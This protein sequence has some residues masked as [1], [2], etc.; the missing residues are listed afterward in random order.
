VLV[1]GSHFH[2]VFGTIHGASNVVYLAGSHNA[3]DDGDGSSACAQA[4]LT[5]THSR[6][7]GVVSEATT[8]TT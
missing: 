5:Y 2:C 3:S 4:F 8:S 6:G 1:G 7:V